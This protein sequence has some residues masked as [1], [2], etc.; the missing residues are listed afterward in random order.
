MIIN[1]LTVYVPKSSD[2]YKLNLKKC[3]IIA[4]KK[5]TGNQL[6][7]FYKAG[8]L[9]GGTQSPEIVP[10]LKARGYNKILQSDEID[11]KEDSMEFWYSIY[12]V[13]SF[14]TWSPDFVLTFINMGN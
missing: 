2:I 3:N 1:G 14:N 6:Q 5:L 8:R 9:S 13:F 12:V 10:L 7:W 11:L 4:F